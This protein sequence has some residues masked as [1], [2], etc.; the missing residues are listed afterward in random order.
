MNGRGVRFEG[1]RRLDARRFRLTA[2]VDASSSFFDGHF[3]GRPVLS[4]VA[5]LALVEEACERALGRVRTPKGVPYA[6][7]RRPIGPNENLAITL[8]A[9]GDAVDF[10]IEVGG[11]TAS[12]GRWTLEAEVV[13]ADA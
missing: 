9:R 12:R 7:F 2:S 1:C 3:P 13:E 11:E 4:A 6:R 5:Q 10:A 8:I